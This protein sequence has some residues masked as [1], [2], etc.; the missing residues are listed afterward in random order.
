M[1]KGEILERWLNLNKEIEAQRERKRFADARI[2]D[3]LE[4]RDKDLVPHMLAHVP[5]HINQRVLVSPL[6]YDTP[7]GMKPLVEQEIQQEAFILSVY[8]QL[9]KAK[10]DFQYMYNVLYV[11]NG[12]VE[13]VYE[14]QITGTA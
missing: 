8:P 5:W 11:D 6:N 1:T 3:L 4:N 7:E 2:K 12:T 10:T 14:Q 9:N 13:S